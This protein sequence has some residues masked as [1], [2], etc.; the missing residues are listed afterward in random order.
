MQTISQNNRNK[1]S[2]VLQTIDF[3]IK[4]P[5]FLLSAKLI[6]IIKLA[7]LFI[8]HLLLRNEEE[9]SS[10]FVSSNDGQNPTYVFTALW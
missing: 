1:R 10:P 4:K 5:V 8:P 7:F 9:V 2:Q 6:R 3:I